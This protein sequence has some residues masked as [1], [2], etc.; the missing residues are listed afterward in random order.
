MF[1]K[2][3]LNKSYLLLLYDKFYIQNGLNFCILH[4][5]FTRKYPLRGYC[6]APL[7]GR[8]D[9]IRWPDLQF[10]LECYVTLRDVT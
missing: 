8:G 9:Q 10:I 6:L 2:I 4:L 7:E 3:Q 1:V 5:S